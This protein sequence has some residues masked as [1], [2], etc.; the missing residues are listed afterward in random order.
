MF[1]RSHITPTLLTGVILAA[2]LVGFSPGDEPRAKATLGPLRAVTIPAGAFDP[3]NDET[4]FSNTGWHLTSDSPH[5]AFISFPAETV[6]LTQVKVRV[7][8]NASTAG[9][10]CVSLYREV[11]ADAA[12]EF[13]G[14]DCTVGASTT[15]PQTLTITA[16]KRIGRFH[17]AF[18][19][20]VFDAK[21]FNLALY[22]ATV[23]YRVVN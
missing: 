22:G 4:D 20:A 2:A 10:L 18:L 16:F 19:W 7:Y 1:R 14:Q 6:L 5:G 12:S 9:N 21:D 13:L 3:V 15:D 11:P 17:S 23:F 8:D